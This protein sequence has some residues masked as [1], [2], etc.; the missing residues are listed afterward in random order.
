MV[1]IGAKG[2]PCPVCK[3]EVGEPCKYINEP[4]RVGVPMTS[5]HNGRVWDA[6]EAQRA[7][8]ILLDL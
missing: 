1:F 3:A 8:N 5:H 7:M 6:H 4:R 2:V